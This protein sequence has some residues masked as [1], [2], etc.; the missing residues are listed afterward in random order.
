LAQNLSA[1]AD[2]AYVVNAS[3]L[4]KP[5]L[6]AG[7]FGVVTIDGERIMYRERDV[8]NNT[9]SGLR[10]GTAGTATTSHNT[11]AEVY[12]LNAGN[13]L[14]IQYQDYVVKDTSIG[15][16]STVLYT[17][18]SLT[19]ADFGDSALI[20]AETLEV[21]VGGIRQY[22]VG[23][24]RFGDVIA[25]QYPYTVVDDAPVT[26][27]FYTTSSVVDPVL[28]PPANVEITILQRR[29]TSWYGTGIKETTGLALQE[30]DTPQARFLCNR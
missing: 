16:G 29:G 7:I 28:A 22:P 2:I 27:E 15:D 3:A 20:F 25:C 8:V 14:D 6:N 1:S 12:S 21:Y 13:L 19:I 9:L 24:N 5:D 23:P 18:P 26:I 10:R 11:G 30:T 17:A 4:G